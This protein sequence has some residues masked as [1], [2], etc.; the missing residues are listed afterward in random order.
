MWGDASS[1]WLECGEKGGSVKESNR[2]FWV[3]ILI[4]GAVVFLTIAGSIFLLYRT[5]VEE[6]K[7]RLLEVVESQAR[8]IDVFSRATSEGDRGGEQAIRLKDFFRSLAESVSRDG[9]EQKQPALKFFIAGRQDESV[10]YYSGTP[11]LMAK[12]VPWTR[13]DGRP[14]GFALNGESGVLETTDH[15]GNSILCSFTYVE[16]VRVG[17][18]A[19][20]LLQDIRK[21]FIR[22]GIITYLSSLLLLVA[23]G[24]I[25][26][27]IVSPLVR[28][29]EEKKKE[30]EVINR[31]LHKLATTDH[32]TALCNR[33]HFAHQIENTLLLAERHKEE[34]AVILFDI[35]RF[36]QI[37]D[38]LG[39]PAGDSVLREMSQLIQGEIRRTDILARWGGEE[40]ILMAFGARPQDAMELAR[41]LCDRVAGY[42][43]SIERQVTCSFGVAVFSPPDTSDSLISRADDALYEAKR[44]GRNR[45]AYREKL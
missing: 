8:F 18:V 37:N 45:V 36:K 24:F 28:R 43:F 16:S 13:L 12:P 14:M 1:E 11:K 31:N 22:T 42:S 4:T 32:L 15:M 6:Q 21:P 2:I 17:I 9:R 40:F 26:K 38:S 25:M 34:V 10:I 27:L 29:L 7:E 23:C 39:H 30:V 35:D 3:T 44:A 41:K 33:Q 20:L 5:A 19:K